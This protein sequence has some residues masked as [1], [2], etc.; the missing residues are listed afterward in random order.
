MSKKQECKA[1]MLPILDAMYVLQGKWKLPIILS[2]SF[3][4]K[5]FGEIEKEV[6]GITPR[7]LSKELKHLQENFLVNRKV[8]DSTPVRIEYSLTKH[9]KSLKPVILALKNWGEKHRKVVFLKEG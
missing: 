6:L 1:A 3:E 7:M 4:P 5:G 2:L 8:I 9:G